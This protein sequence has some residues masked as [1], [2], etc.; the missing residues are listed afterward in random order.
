M[1][2]FLVLFTY[3]ALYYSEPNTAIE[4]F[5]LLC[6]TFPKETKIPLSHQIQ[7]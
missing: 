4:Y 5:N 6:L 3:I 7:I 1:I 2:D